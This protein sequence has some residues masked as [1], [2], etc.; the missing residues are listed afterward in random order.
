MAYD[1]YGFTEF[2]KDIDEKN[3]YGFR[4][5]NDLISTYSSKDS[6]L[7]PLKEYPH[8]LEHPSLFCLFT[9]QIIETSKGYELKF[10]K[11]DIRLFNYE[12]YKDLLDR[13]LK[14]TLNQDTLR[15]F[16]KYQ[17]L[18]HIAN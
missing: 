3:Y 6:P 15:M 18:Q 10:N 16:K 1:Y 12:E 13:L 5:Y 8:I 9:N 17:A 7:N 2:N 11:I 4:N 14:E